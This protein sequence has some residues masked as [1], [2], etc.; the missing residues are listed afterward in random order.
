MPPDDVRRHRRARPPEVITSPANQVVRLVRSLSRRKGRE[1]AGQFVVEG[2]RGVLD[3]LD[4]GVRPDI[5]VVREDYVPG[6]LPLADLIGGG[7]VDLRVLDR[8]LFDDLSDTVPPQGILGLL[9]LPKAGS[10]RGDATL[11]VYLDGI[12]DPG[13]MG[14]LLRSSAAAGVDAVVVGAGSVDA[15]NAKVVRS[16]MGAHFR[17]PILPA[18]TVSLDLLRTLPVRALAEA[19]ADQTYDGIDWSLP[20]LLIVGSEADGPGASGRELANLGITIP[21]A[22]GVESLNAGVAGSVILFE[23]ARQRRT[24][25]LRALK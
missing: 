2:E 9:P 12:R 19:G 1:E 4:A 6:P 11:V 3:A 5:V 24:G 14:T 7:E 18:S 22:G 10:L 23:I 15:Y 13:N 17:V 8:A 25:S 21:M 20:A 16:A